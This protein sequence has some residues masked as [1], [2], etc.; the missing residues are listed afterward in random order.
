[1]D[2]YAFPSTLKEWKMEIDVAYD[3]EKWSQLELVVYENG[4]DLV[5]DQL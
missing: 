4:L 3:S 1:M 2:E 5:S